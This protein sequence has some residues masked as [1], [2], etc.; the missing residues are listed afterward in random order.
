MTTAPSKRT[1]TD[2]MCDS[3]ERQIMRRLEK[4]YEKI[5]THKPAEDSFF[6][7]L[8]KLQEKITVRLAERPITKAEIN[9]V[10]DKAGK[11]S[12]ALLKEEAKK[13]A[14]PRYRECIGLDGTTRLIPDYD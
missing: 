13:V 1:V 2:R 7:R 5:F 12:R 4:D 10:V 9:G 11:L 8:T 6:E 3:A 14:Q